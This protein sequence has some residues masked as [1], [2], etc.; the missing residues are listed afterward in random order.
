MEG[1][2]MNMREVLEA[3]VEYSELVCR[4]GIFNR[5]RLIAITTKARA[6][7]AAP[8]RNCDAG[9]AEEQ[10]ERFYAYCKGRSCA[11]CAIRKFPNPFCGIRWAQMPYEEGVKK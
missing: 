5:D 7:L 9:T 6:A 11:D 1:T 10:G 2:Q 3:F 4:M 8:V